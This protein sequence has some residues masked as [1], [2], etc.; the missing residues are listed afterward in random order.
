MIKSKHPHLKREAHTIEA[1]IH[2]YCEKQH[3]CQGQLCSEC[4]ELLNYANDRLDHCPF[5]EEKSTC[6]NCQVHC[7]KPEMRQRIREVMIFSGPR[8]ITRHPY[9]A[10]MHLAVDGRRRAPT[11]KKGKEKKAGSSS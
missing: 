3:G 9:L 7:Y 4:S 2:I 10:F 5:Q 1:M 8:M 11:L 6:A